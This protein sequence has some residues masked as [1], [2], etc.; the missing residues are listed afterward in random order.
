MIDN[1]CIPKDTP[2]VN[3]EHCGLCRARSPH[4]G[5]LTSLL[6][7]L[8]AHYMTS[9]D[10]RMHG[11]DKRLTNKDDLEKGIVHG[12]LNINEIRD[13]ILDLGSPSDIRQ[14]QL[15]TGLRLFPSEMRK[16]NMWRNIFLQSD[17]LD[18]LI[19]INTRVLLVGKDLQMLVDRCAESAQAKPLPN[20]WVV[21]LMMVDVMTLPSEP[22]KKLFEQLFTMSLWPK[23]VTYVVDGVEII[24]LYE[25]TV[26]LCIPDI[27]LY[28]Y[29][30]YYKERMLSA[31][32]QGGLFD[33]LFK[34][35]GGD[36]AQTQ[37][38]YLTRDSN[39]VF[40]ASLQRMD[41][42]WRCDDENM[43]ALTKIC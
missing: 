10:E 28:R 29:N 37:Y 4:F 18:F 43:A 34:R 27:S 24:L 8:Y 17:W 39:R 35:E 42:D 1:T 33:S 7:E 38:M 26:L 36:D 2:L 20:K 9:A 31:D 6:G 14:F 23:K 3:F 11:L 16:T 21:L 32:L 19:Q 5:D 41:S 40:T 22:E 13:A 25:T 12:F 30:Q 15:A